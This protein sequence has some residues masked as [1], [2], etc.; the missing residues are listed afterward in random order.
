MIRDM[1]TILVRYK[2]SATHAETNEALVRAVFEE[3]RAGAAEGIR[4]A[5]YRLPDG[6]TFV[7]I[8]TLEQPDRNPL[9][10]LASFQTFQKQ[11]EGRCEEPAV[12]TE[13]TPVD[14]YAA[15]GL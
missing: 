11:L 3:L 5:S 8:A 7:H 10:A 6:A 9:R 2:T 13:L 4:Y 15:V 1:K 12:V 14:S